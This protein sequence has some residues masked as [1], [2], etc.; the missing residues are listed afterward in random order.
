MIMIPICS[1]GDSRETKSSRYDF[2]LQ[3]CEK[4]EDISQAKTLADAR[5]FA[6]EGTALVSERNRLLKIADAYGWDTVEIYSQDPPAIDYEASKGEK[7]S[8]RSSR[9][10]EEGKRVEIKPQVETSQP[11]PQGSARSRIKDGGSSAGRSTTIMAEAGTS[12]LPPPQRLLWSTRNFHSFH[13]VIAVGDP[14][15]FSEISLSQPRSG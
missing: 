4:L 10:E 9:K 2:D 12:A 6:H 15:I 7:G 5:R 11:R 14:V 8:Y 13:A 3:V 1:S